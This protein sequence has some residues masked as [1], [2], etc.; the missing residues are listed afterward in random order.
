MW[1]KIKV[2]VMTK[3]MLYFIDAEDQLTIMHVNDSKDLRTHFN[4][5]KQH[6][7][8]MTKRH[9]NLVRM[10]SKISDTRFATLIMSSLPPSYCSAIQT[11]TAAERMGAMQGTASKAKMLPDDLVNFFVEEVHHPLIDHERSK[12]TDSVLVALAK[13]TKGSN[14]SKGNRKPKTTPDVRCENCSKGGHTKADC[15]AKGSDKEGQGLR[16]GPRQGKAKK[17]EKSDDAAIVADNMPN[18]EDLFTFTCTSDL[19]ALAESINIP[20]GHLNACIDSGTSNHYCPDRAKFI[21]YRLITGHTMM[22]TD[23]WRLQAAGIGD[24]HIQLLNGT[25]KMK[26]LLKKAVHTPDMAFTLIS[27]SHLDQAT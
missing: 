13:N 12:V 19:S 3:S 17:P 22:T 6:F 9:D 25:G 16:Q 7:E 10:G 23:S 4:E 26:A 1:E 2:D 15:W 21:N 5:L 8:L 20:Q 11:I 18:N 27:I 24:V 14:S